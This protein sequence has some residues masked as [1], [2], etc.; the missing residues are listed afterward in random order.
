VHRWRWR[1][2]KQE[3]HKQTWTSGVGVIDRLP[4]PRGQPSYHAQLS[5]RALAD[6]RV[7]CARLALRP[8]QQQQQQQ[9]QPAAAAAST[10]A[11]AAA[12]TNAGGGAMMRPLPPMSKY[13][14]RNILIMIRNLD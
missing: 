11:A 13:Y 8:S 4:V 12:A 2:S 3:R 9:Q 5:D 6:E 10:G 1:G 14:L 7:T